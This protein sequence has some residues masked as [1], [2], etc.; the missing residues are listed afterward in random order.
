MRLRPIADPRPDSGTLLAVPPLYSAI[1]RFSLI[2]LLVPIVGSV[3]LIRGIFGGEGL[4]AVIALAV[5][6]FTLFNRHKRY[7]LFTDALVVRYLAFRTRVVE[8][9][10]IQEVKLL[11]QPLVGP[12]LLI[13][14]KGGPRLIIRPKDPQEMVSRLNAVLNK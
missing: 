4:S 2:D 14:R 1:H 8:L 5:G 9:S 6:A 7:D 3:L 12:V 13:N 11:G 10:D